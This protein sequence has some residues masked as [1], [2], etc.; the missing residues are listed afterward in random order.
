MNLYQEYRDDYDTKSQ[1]VITNRDLVLEAV[2]SFAEQVKLKKL[3]TT[4]AQTVINKPN[5]AELIISVDTL[6]DVISE[7][8]KKTDNFEQQRKTDSQ[9]IERHY[10][11][12]IYDDVKILEGEVKTLGDKLVELNDG[13][14]GDIDNVGKT[15]L[16]AR[17]AENK[18]KISSSHKA[19]DILNTSLRTFLGHDEITFSVNDDDTGYLIMRRGNSARSLSEGERTAIA[20][21][22]FVTQLSDENFDPT[23]GIIVIDDPISSL[24]ANSQF[25]AFSFLKT[26]TL[27][28]SQLFILTHN[29]DFLKL[30]TSWIK[31]SRKGFALY[32]VKNK[33]NET[34]GSRTAFIDKL[35]PALEKFESEYHYLFNVLYGYKDD[36]TI[37]NAYKMPNIARK[38]LDSFLMFCIPKNIGTYDRL[39]EVVFDEEKKTAIYKFVNDQSHIT[40]AGFD[41]SLVPET[42]K[43]ITYL[44]E[45]MEKTFPTHYKYLVETAT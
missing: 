21:I 41:P 35:D 20:F 44:M 33:F 4:E 43:C 6:N 22:F 14:V 17:I 23:T 37:E 19:C 38:L 11:S 45:L 25:Q 12:S 5:L 34:D 7:H 36:G 3:H 2:T 27:N 10:L 29:F 26:A 30:V 32:M 42:Q 16:V 39:Q 9:K 40:G 31:N 13:I 8:N 18:A 1:A 15:K 28:A 24:D